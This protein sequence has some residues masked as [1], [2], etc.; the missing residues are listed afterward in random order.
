MMPEDHVYASAFEVVQRA[1]ALAGDI[2]AHIAEAERHTSPEVDELER[3][4]ASLRDIIHVS[5]FVAGQLEGG[6][7]K[8][9]AAE[10][11]KAANSTLSHLL[12]EELES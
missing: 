12:D 8:E 7:T 2:Q 3:L 6:L 11:R 4:A 9:F 5:A 10:A 1:K